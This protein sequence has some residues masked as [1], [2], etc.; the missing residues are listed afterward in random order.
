MKKTDNSFIF[1]NKGDDLKQY[2]P[3]TVPEI[4]TFEAYSVKDAHKEKLNFKHLPCIS[5]IIPQLLEI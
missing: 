3:L 5:L 2:L 4:E 1:L